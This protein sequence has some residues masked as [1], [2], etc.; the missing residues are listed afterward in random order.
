M[1]EHRMEDDRV[2]EFNDPAGLRDIAGWLTTPALSG[3]Y[4]SAADLQ[5]V[6]DSA[7]LGRLPQNRRFAVEQLFRSAA[8]DGRLPELFDGLQ[9]EL[10]AHKQA[11]L[12]CDTP[13]L[14]RWII[15]VEA[16]LERLNTMRLASTS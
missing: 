9:T 10:V 3:V 13:Y 2:P 12:D 14:N 5:R 1:E 11:Y 15:A 4:L 7:G 6:G 16:S 8:I